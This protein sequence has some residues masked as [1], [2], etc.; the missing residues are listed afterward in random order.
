MLFGPDKVLEAVS[1]WLSLIPGRSGVVLRAA[2]YS[3]VLT[4]CDWSVFIGFG[5]LLARV[6]TILGENVYIGPYC[7]LGLVTIGR[8]TLLGPGVQIPSGPHTHTFDRLDLPIR[9][10]PSAGVRV[11]VGEDCW[12]GANSIVMADV[13]SKTVLGAGSVVTKPVPARC[14]AAG[15]PA[16][17]IRQR[18]N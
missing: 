16:K 1:Q 2:F 10:Q 17:V 9:E 8:D 5:V 14:F 18:E 13:G 6:E 12:L 3:R 11:T 4:R 7:Q 15:V